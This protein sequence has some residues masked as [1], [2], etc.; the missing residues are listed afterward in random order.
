MAAC[1]SIAG[2]ANRLI[3]SLTDNQHQRRPRSEDFIADMK[4]NEYYMI[5]KNGYVHMRH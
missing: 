2:G 5:V 1:V 4:H 3:Y